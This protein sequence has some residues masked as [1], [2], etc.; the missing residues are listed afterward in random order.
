ML[1]YKS[2]QART[3]KCETENPES[4]DSNYQIKME[5]KFNEI[6]NLLE[7]VLFKTTETHIFILA[8]G[9]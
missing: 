2:I 5:P 1:P 7:K 4:K 9:F 3:W 6:F 8:M